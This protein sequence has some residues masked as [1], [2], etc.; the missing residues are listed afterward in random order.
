M[1]NPYR[2]SFRVPSVLF[3]FKVKMLTVPRSVGPLFDKIISPLSWR[4]FGTADDLRFLKDLYRFELAVERFKYELRRP[5]KPML[6]WL[7]GGHVYCTKCY[8]CALPA[9]PWDHVCACGAERFQVT[10]Y[11]LEFC[12]KCDRYTRKP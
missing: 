10:Q 4:L 1:K 7:T 8:L 11:G 6:C 12:G 3:G 5:F 9:Q 2:V